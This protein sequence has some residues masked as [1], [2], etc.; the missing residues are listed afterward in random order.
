[1]NSLD[2]FFNCL[3]NEDYS[4]AKQLLK[5]TVKE[6]IKERVQKKVKEM[7]GGEAC[8]MGSPD[9]SLKKI[10]EGK[11]KGLDVIDVGKVLSDPEALKNLKKHQTEL[12]P[13]K[14][15]KVGKMGSSKIGE[16]KKSK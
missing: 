15:I 5:H 6:K 9:K 14:E 7:R 13:K 11:K 2:N 3:I 10:G 1:M 4:K 8:P 16:G 12:P